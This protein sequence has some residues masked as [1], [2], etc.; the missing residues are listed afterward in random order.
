MSLISPTMWRDLTQDPI[1][2]RYA[3]LLELVLFGRDS[4]TGALTFLEFQQ[5][6]SGGLEGLDF[7][8]SVRRALTG[9]TSIAPIE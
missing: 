8:I 5:N 4:S 7:A 2:R 9:R 3:G 6:I 1:T